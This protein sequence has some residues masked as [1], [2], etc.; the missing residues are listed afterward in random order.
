[1]KYFHKAVPR[2]K[3]IFSLVVSLLGGVSCSDPSGPSAQEIIGVWNWIES[4]G[5]FA[6][7]RMT[8][9]M[10]GRTEKLVFGLKGAYERYANGKLE[11]RGR[12]WVE[13]KRL[14]SGVEVDMLKT[15][16]R[17]FDAIVTFSSRDTLILN[18]Y[19]MDCWK[20]TYVRVGESY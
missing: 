2:R 20:K 1:M 19:C 3:Y 18:E 4:V 11:A 12:Y 16:G 7:T 5:G 8:P 17:S 9:E 14:A 10:I 15:D 6:G 13:R